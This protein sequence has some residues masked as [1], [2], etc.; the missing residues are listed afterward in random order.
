MGHMTRNDGGNDRER[1]L[2]FL[3]VDNDLKGREEGEVRV[4]MK[5]ECGCI[6]TKMS[7]HLRTT[8]HKRMIT[9]A[10]EME[11]KSERKGL[12]EKPKF[13]GK[14]VWEGNKVYY[15]EEEED[16]L[17]VV[18]GDEEEKRK[19]L[20]TRVEWE[21]GFDPTRRGA[22]ASGT[23]GGN[24][25]Y[26]KEVFEGDEEETVHEIGGRTKVVEGKVVWRGVS[27]P[28]EEG[29]APATP[30]QGN[31]AYYEPAEEKLEEN[32]KWAQCPYEKPVFDGDMVWRECEGKWLVTLD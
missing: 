31:V 3:H 6:V 5:C 29:L 32:M 18:E 23:E 24:R 10:L 25:V 1:K 28:H 26:M 22:R 12:Q 9:K 16:D 30:R 15:E 2:S 17:K 7:K 27:S 20:G 21:W 14:V 19:Y 11:E 8:K 4:R 13:T